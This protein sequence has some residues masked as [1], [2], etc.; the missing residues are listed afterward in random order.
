MEDLVKNTKIVD[1]ELVKAVGTLL[2]GESLERILDETRIIT[3]KRLL[4][5]VKSRHFSTAIHLVEHLKSANLTRE[6]VHTILTW[7][8][9][10]EAVPEKLREATKALLT[11]GLVNSVFE[12]V[13]EIEPI[14]EP[15]IRSICCL[16]P[17]AD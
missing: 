2:P 8:Q 14:V 15:K 16:H 12:F 5:V 9:E 10:D 6:D 13:S 7:I 3:L 17:R 1:A 4:N 11:S